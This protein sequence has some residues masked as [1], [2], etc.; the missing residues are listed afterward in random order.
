MTTGKLLTAEQSVRL[1]MMDNAER[2]ELI[3]AIVA[4]LRYTAKGNRRK[5]G[6]R[7]SPH[8]FYS[9]LAKR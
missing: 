1:A 5:N 3:A 6:W 7:W 9:R 2:E 8:I 4:A